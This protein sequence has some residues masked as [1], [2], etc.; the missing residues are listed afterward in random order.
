LGEGR[1]RDPVV[2]L[3]RGGVGLDR[4]P[5]GE[6]HLDAELSHQLEVG[7]DGLL[8]WR[9]GRVEH[10]A[11]A[12][13]V[14]DENRA[15]VRPAQLGEIEGGPAHTVFTQSQYSAPTYAPVVLPELP[16]ALRDTVTVFE[17]V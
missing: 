2:R 3:E 4:L 1:G 8:G 9:Q 11:R 17:T 5:L 12:V 16:R 6:G 15:E 7:K 13:D 10:D 14:A